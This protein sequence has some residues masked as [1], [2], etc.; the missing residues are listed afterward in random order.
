M[1]SPNGL[2]VPSYFPRWPSST[3]P[4]QF[5]VKAASGRRRAPS[6]DLPSAEGHTPKPHFRCPCPSPALGKVPAE[7]VLQR[8]HLGSSLTPFH[9]QE[10][11]DGERV[12]EAPQLVK[13]QDPEQH[14]P[15][16]KMDKNT[17]CLLQPRVRIQVHSRSFPNPPRPAG[18]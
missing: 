15:Y 9:V 1:V 18:G 7:R 13:A 17:G 5:G 16:H 3:K 10:N 4:N 8:G 6:G 11:K 14:L 12:P 2:L